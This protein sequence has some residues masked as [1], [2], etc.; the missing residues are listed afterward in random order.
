MKN[1]RYSATITVVSGIGTVVL[2]SFY[3]MK[4]SGGSIEQVIITPPTS[5]SEYDF[6]ILNPESTRIYQEKNKKGTFNSD[7]QVNT[8]AGIHTLGIENGTDGDY[9][10]ELTF[11]GDW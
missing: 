1:I 11:R 8:I 5:D 10:V 2:S 7:K 9:T 6:Y 3:P 4:H